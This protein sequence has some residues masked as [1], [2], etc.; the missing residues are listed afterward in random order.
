M[1][2]PVPQGGPYALGATPGKD[3]THFALYSQH[4]ESVSL[5]LFD[6]PASGDP[7]ETIAL[8][9]GTNGVFRAFVAGVGPGQVYGYRVSGPWDPRNGHRFDSSKTLLDPYARAI[10]RRVR[11]GPEM[12]SYRAATYPD[13]SALESPPNGASSAASCPLGIVTDS[14]PRVPAGDRP[15]T[16]WRDTV[17]YEL[18]VRGFTKLH[19][20][21]PPEERGTYAGLAAEPVLDYLQRL[22]VTAVELLPVQHHLDDHRL[23]RE[24]L[25]NYWGYQPLAYFAPEPTYAQAPG[26]GAVDEFRD[27]VGRFHERGIE[28]IL[29]VVFNHTGESGHDG[30]TLSFRGID[31]ASYYRLDPRDRRRY[32]NFS[33]CGN[34]LNTDHPA[35]VRMVTDCLRYW[36]E[37]MG[38]DG[39]RF[40]LATSLGRGEHRYSRR[41]AL[42]SAIR[43]DPVLQGIKFVAEPWDVNGPDSDQLGHFP[44]GWAEWNRCFRD[45]AR[46]Y[47]RGDRGM[48][49]LLATRLAGSSD[50]FGYRRRS[51]Q[52]GVNLVTSHDGFTLMDLVSYAHRRNDAN[53]EGGFD[54]ER[55][56]HS[57]NCGAE[58]PS[59]DPKIRELRARQRRN[60]LVT[61]L[62][63]QGV[64]MLV[65]GDE[66]GRTQRGNNN[67]YCQDN[68][69]SWVD[70]T[71]ER[72][73]PL[74][75]FV[76]RLVQLRASDDAFRR[77]AF[78]DGRPEP[79]TER[80]DVTWLRPDG[81]EIS[82]A[83]WRDPGLECFGA[84]IASARRHRNLLLF[85]GSYRSWMFRLPPA[86]WA[87]VFDTR[88]PAFAKRAAAAGGTYRVLDRTCALL[89]ADW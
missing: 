38:V 59:A 76:R 15:G 16:A 63:S 87:A 43:Q 10:A 86:N 89:R 30:P 75:E 36:V 64:P 50:I 20:D 78:L 45:D 28:V 65:A 19:P 51:P 44:A 46:K 27:M 6:S 54:G 34:S 11:W 48:V 42:L 39:F 32:L 41:A 1:D 8:G 17:I 13:P 72:D 82:E 61:L 52:A 40:D 60:L 85:N 9:G 33:G 2:S 73:N 29:D 57:W 74:V 71:L 31:N 62:L 47:W 37:A 53:L 49:P 69:T 5:C 35:V 22:G 80:K 21:V 4:A 56:S 67:P 81:A 58:G 68:E 25:T 83:D 3:G 55:A 26:A 84:M 12:Y 18:H 14:P 24:G 7:S 66:F 77:T 23:E 70:W 88:K 79:D